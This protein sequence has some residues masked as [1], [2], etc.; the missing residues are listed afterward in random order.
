MITDDEQLITDTEL[1]TWLGI[2]RNTARAWRQAGKLQFLKTPGG[3]VIRY[4]ERYVKELIKRGELAAAR[5]HK[6][7]R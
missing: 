3:R 5:E 2:S 7:M 6:G 1:C 4:R